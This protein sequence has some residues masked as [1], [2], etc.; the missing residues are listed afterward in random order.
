[1]YWVLAFELL[2]CVF[3]LLTSAMIARVIFISLVYRKEE[4]SIDE[5]SEM[6][7]IV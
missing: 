7:D 4:K 3:A 2:F 1:M 6:Y 5:A